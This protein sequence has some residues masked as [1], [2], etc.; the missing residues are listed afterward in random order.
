MFSQGSDIRHRG[1]NADKETTE[2]ANCEE[3]L[4]GF[5]RTPNKIIRNAQL[6]HKQIQKIATWEFYGLSKMIAKMIVYLFTTIKTVWCSVW[7]INICVSSTARY[8]YT[9]W[10]LT[11]LHTVSSDI[12]STVC[13]A[14]PPR[15]PCLI[16]YSYPLLIIQQGASFYWSCVKVNET[17]RFPFKTLKSC[18]LIYCLLHRTHMYRTHSVSLDQEQPE[19]C[20]GPFQSC[21]GPS[22]T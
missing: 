22:T 7:A 14:T 9:D 17:K 10:G 15:R 8:L 13:T 6:K 2:H 1:R 4:T 3:N 5:I 21:H 11:R 16:F 19:E 12:N 18:Q 20:W